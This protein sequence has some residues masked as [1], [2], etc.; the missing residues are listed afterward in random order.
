MSTNLSLVTE[1]NQA[2]RQCISSDPSLTTDSHA[3]DLFEAYVFTLILL[4][5][6][7]L[8]ASISYEDV[9]GR[10]PSRFVFRTSPGYIYSTERSYCHALIDFPGKPPLEAHV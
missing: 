8:G 5:A 3:S 2:L 1:I 9:F 10:R 6:D 4:A 7:D